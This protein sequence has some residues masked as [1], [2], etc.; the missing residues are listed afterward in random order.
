[1]PTAVLRRPCAALLAAALAL[2]AI[3]VA[4]PGVGAQAPRAP[5]ATVNSCDPAS[6]PGSV[7]VRVFVPPRQRAA[8][9]IRIRMQFFDAG[10]NQW[11][12]VRSGGDAGFA[13]L[14]SGRRRLF[15][16]TTF[17]FPEPRAGRRLKLR[18]LVNVEWRL[19]TQV[20]SS[21]RLTTRGGHRRAS[22]PLL[23]TSAP[24]CEIRR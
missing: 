23:R 7:G 17:T 9:W 6:R 19:G 20:V 2:C 14:G 22:D 16:G 5:W 1:M 21:A 15:G 3:A 8:Q 4:A 13:R 18:G 12:F 11:R 10:R 24:F